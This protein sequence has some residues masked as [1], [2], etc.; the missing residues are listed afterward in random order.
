LL[1]AIYASELKNRLASI[2]GY[3]TQAAVAT[4]GNVKGLVDIQVGRASF[5]LELS[6]RSPELIYL[7]PSQPAELRQAVLHAY[8]RSINTIWI[9]ATPLLFLG[10]VFCIFLKHYSL[11]RNIVRADVSKKAGDTESEETKLEEIVS[12]A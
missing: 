8:T 2:P 3:A 4:S 7:Y 12:K 11:E 10:A 9:V 6:C 1:G 5:G